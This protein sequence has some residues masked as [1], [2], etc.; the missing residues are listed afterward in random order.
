MKFPRRYPDDRSIL[1]VQLNDLERVL[2]A[3]DK[4]VVYFVPNLHQKSFQ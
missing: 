1:F 4:I 2:A 3:E